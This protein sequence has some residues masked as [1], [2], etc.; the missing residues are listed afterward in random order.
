[1]NPS[2]PV[3]VP[4]AAGPAGGFSCGGF[5]MPGRAGGMPG[6]HFPRR[7]SAV[8]RPRAAEVKEVEE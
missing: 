7:K 6:T 3:Q 5:P 2:G 8:S 4:G 1:M